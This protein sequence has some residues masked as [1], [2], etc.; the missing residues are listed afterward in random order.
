[1]FPFSAQPIKAVILHIANNKRDFPGTKEKLYRNQLQKLRAQREKNW[2][3]LMDVS[4]SIQRI[5]H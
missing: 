2:F 5:L 3:R 4:S 1:M